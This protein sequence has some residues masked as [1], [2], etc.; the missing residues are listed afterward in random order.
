MHGSERLRRQGLVFPQPLTRGVPWRH[1]PKS[2]V[3]P[4]LPPP[5]M[6]DVSHC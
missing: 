6:G 3:P 5:P 4:Y 1:S 2:Q